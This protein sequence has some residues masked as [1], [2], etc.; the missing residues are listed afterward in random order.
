MAMTPDRGA[1][2]LAR[3]CVFALVATGLSAA[4]HAAGGG[5]FP[6]PA[7]FAVVGPPVALLALWLSSRRR[8]L[9]A[10]SG[11][12]ALVQ[13]LLHVVFHLAHAGPVTPQLDTGHGVP[14]G[15]G[16]HVGGVHA[17]GRQGVGVLAVLT[18]PPPTMVLG[19]LVAVVLTAWIMARG[20]QALWRV[21]Q[22]LTVRPAPE[23]PALAPLR[24]L[25]KVTT[26]LRRLVSR[27]SGRVV[28]S[29]GPPA[30]WLA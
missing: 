5:G 27:C 13:G 30:P 23:V 10:L 15:T 1:P 8:G 17:A 9:P 28:A 22:R 29:R 24:S 4:G 21:V 16:H 26:D 14:L 25:A 19:H 12:L 6:S 3:A 2:R 7:V 11:V 18:P 20:E